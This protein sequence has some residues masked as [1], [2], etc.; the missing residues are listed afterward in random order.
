MHPY[1]RIRTKGQSYQGKFNL[2]SSIS[3]GDW[4]RKK[5]VLFRLREW[6]LYKWKNSTLHLCWVFKN[7][8]VTAWTHCERASRILFGKKIK[9]IKNYVTSTLI[10]KVATDYYGNAYSSMYN[11]KIVYT[12]INIYIMKNIFT[13]IR[14]DSIMLDISFCLFFNI[15]IT[16]QKLAN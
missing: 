3:G 7:L 15:R 9:C 11:S 13:R 8:I 16:K 14:R 6:I 2:E 12:K 10:N 1:L 5:H 4:H